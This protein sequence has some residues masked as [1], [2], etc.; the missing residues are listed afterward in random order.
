[1]TCIDVDDALLAGWPLPMPAEDDDKERRGRTLVVGGSPE[2]P[3]ALLLA[4][5]AALRAGCGKVL[6]ATAASIATH[7][8]L[9]LPEARVVA[10]PASV[11]GAVAA[12]APWAPRVAALLIGPG[13]VDDACV[14]LTRR[15]LPHFTGRPV[16]LDAGAL[17]AATSLVSGG[18]L[19]APHAGEMARLAG[20]EKAAIERDPA[21]AAVQGA[22]RWN[23]TVVLK[24][25]VTFIATPQGRLWR[26]DGRGLVGLATSGSGDVLAGLVAGL[27][28]RGAALEQAA[29]W[30]VALHAR[31]GAALARHVGT[32]GYLAREL[33][34]EVP[35]LSRP[36]DP[37]MRAT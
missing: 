30:G 10:L 3:G 14:E 36:Y 33:A 11:D 15:L 23:A 22:A 19:I 1:M 2:V 16:V 27:A 31:A 20:T 34:G 12:L 24:G 29:V 25:A 37:S 28:A 5:E 9:A 6:V 26:H 8:G 18:T 7:V 21:A 35:S 17:E 4:G 13:L 32:L